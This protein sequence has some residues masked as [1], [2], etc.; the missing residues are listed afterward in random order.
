MRNPKYI[1]K[2]LLVLQISSFAWSYGVGH[3]DAETIDVGHA[4]SSAARDQF[5]IDAAIRRGM[6]GDAV[7][8]LLRTKKPVV[9][10]K[11]QPNGTTKTTTYSLDPDGSISSKTVTE[12]QAV[13]HYDSGS[14]PDDVNLDDILKSPTGTVTKTFTDKDGAKVTRT[15][16]VSKPATATV[17]DDWTRPYIPTWD[18]NPGFPWSSEPKTPEGGNV[19]KTTTTFVGP[20]GEKRVV[21]K[22]SSQPEI[23]IKEPKFPW[24]VN[25]QTHTVP[26]LQPWPSADPEIVGTDLHRPSSNWPTF[27]FPNFPHAWQPTNSMG[28][29]DEWTVVEGNP[30]V[31]T[32]T[33]KRKFQSWTPKTWNYPDITTSTE[34]ITTTVR[35]TA[36]AKVTTPLPSLDDFLKSQYGHAITTSKT[37]STSTNKAKEPPVATTTQKAITINIDD[38]P[39]MDVL[40]NG[41]P[42]DVNNL[43]R[44]PPYLRPTLDTGNVLKIEN[45]HPIEPEQQTETKQLETNVLNITKTHVGHAKP[46]FQDLDPEMQEILRKANILPEDI[47]SID[48]DTITKTR[49]EPDGRVITTTY[50]VR[51]SSPTPPIKV[52]KP[53]FTSYT[54]TLNSKPLDMPSLLPAAPTTYHAPLYPISPIAEF[55]AKFGLTKSDILAKNGE[56]TRTLIDDDGQVLTATFVLSSPIAPQPPE[57]KPYK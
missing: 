6:D 46:T 19:H 50:K 16:A 14:L 51:S 44:L 43:G 41:K 48:G 31:E 36:Q 3:P 29:P 23:T 4:S 33:T 24:S 13:K 9:K 15:F 22:W 39:V 38:L 55:L 10:V 8:E 2:V 26:R 21:E 54:P 57:K 56:Y 20:N 17:D 42:L 40:H 12:Y 25:T 32:T 35:P 49:K 30:N 52:E 11:A 1:L 47:S 27:N 37:I 53:I 28:D 7:A 18:S 45:K 34:P 5:I